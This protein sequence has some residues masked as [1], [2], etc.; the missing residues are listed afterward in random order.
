M[1]EL[2]CTECNRRLDD[3]PCGFVHA[4]SR[5]QIHALRQMFDALF[6]PLATPPDHSSGRK[7]GEVE[8]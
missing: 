3:R 5:L 8:G 4:L 6:L 1:S 2:R 7:I